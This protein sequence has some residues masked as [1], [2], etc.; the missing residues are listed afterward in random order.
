MGIL[1]FALKSSI[2]GG[3]VYYTVQEGLWSKPEDTI[4]MYCRMYNSVAPYIQKNI[5]EDVTKSLPV[6]PSF[7]TM[8]GCA[9]GMWNKGVMTSIKFTSELPSH[10]SNGID[11]VMSTPAIK[12]LFGDQPET[13]KSQ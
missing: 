6:V 7:V 8:T 9:K 2:A 1:R 13:G 3:I 5:P 4:D 12:E 10:L 11:S